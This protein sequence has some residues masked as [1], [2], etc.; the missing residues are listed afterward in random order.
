MPFTVPPIAQ[1]RVLVTGGRGFLGKQV[2][3]VL[4]SR[5]YTNVVAPSHVEYDLTRA[6]RV[7]AC[8]RELQPDAVV[9][10]AAVVGGIGANRARPGEFFYKNLIMGVELMEQARLAGVRKFVAVG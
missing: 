5:G 8:V 3:D 1:P 9:H 4:S 10:L 6:D 2:L 7:A